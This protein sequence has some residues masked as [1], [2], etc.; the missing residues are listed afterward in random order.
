MT[1]GPGR[2]EPLWDRIDRNRIKVGVFLVFFVLSV[3]VSTAAFVGVSGV[4]VGVMLV[5]A[6]QWDAYFSALPFATVALTALSLVLSVVHVA[7]VLSRPEVRLPIQFGAVPSKMGTLLETKSALHDMAIAAGLEH[8]PQLWV[9]PDCERVNAFVIGLRPE[10]AVI[11]VTHGL[12]SRLDQAEQRAVFANLMARLNAGDVAW[13]TAV[14]AVMGPIWGVRE[15]RLRSQERRDDAEMA[16]AG[17]F[18]AARTGESTGVVA[19]MIV[20][21]LAVLVTEALLAGHE[22]AA[23]AVSEKADAEGMLLLKDPPAMLRA[24]EDVLNANNTVP[25][26][27]EAYSMLFYC[28]AGFGYAPEDDPEM[29]RIDRLRQVLGVA[30]TG[31]LRSTA[32]RAY[33][34]T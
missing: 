30:G 15:A 6:P 32:E 25:G 33:P 11:G 3:A 7:K 12:A 22:R 24:L 16:A 23:W 4:I 19:L 31:G 5:R 9:I 14:S 1:Y 26:A 13:S 29:R 17:T 27:E 21:F 18:A 10:K 8:S 34:S 2:R 20:G 28:W